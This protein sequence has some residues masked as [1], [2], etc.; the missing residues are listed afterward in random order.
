[1]TLTFRRLGVLAAAAVL[2]TAIGLKPMT[3]HAMGTDNPQPPADDSSKKKKKKNDNNV[4][5]QQQ[6][7]QA[8]AKFLRDY[9][10]ARDVILAGNYEGG[11]KA[12]HV[13]VVAER[14]HRLDAALVI[15]GEDLFARGAIV[16]QE[17]RIGLLLLLLLDDVVV[18]LF[19]LLAAVIGRRLRIVSAH[20]V[21]MQRLHADGRRQQSGGGEY[22]KAVEGGLHFGAFPGR[23]AMAGTI[24]LF[25][26]IWKK[27]FVSGQ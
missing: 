15:A 4:I 25:A 2:V 18:F 1:M 17:F 12:M 21:D 26:A 19:L 27:Q 3:V 5:E 10:A 7:Q 24:P 16:A 9:R 20:G 13:L 8:D 22:R 14:V 23:T 11:I 6:K